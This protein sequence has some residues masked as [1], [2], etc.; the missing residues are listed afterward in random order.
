MLLMP[1]VM[2]CGR[3]D[4]TRSQQP[5]PEAPPVPA[6][7][8]PGAAAPGA[9]TPGSPASKQPPVE[10]RI[11]AIG[12]TSSLD[13]ALRRAFDP[14][15]FEPMG[16]PGPNDWLA[17]HPEKPQSYRDWLDQ[18]THVIAGPRR[19]IYL[20]PIGTFPADAPSLDTLITIM[21]AFF[22]IDVRTLPAVTVAAVGAKTRI[23]TGTRKQQLLP[24]MCCAG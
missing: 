15:D 12:D 1:L 23:N 13:P 9:A 8:A 21:R 4:K 3:D 6:A 10:A 20:L 5:R 2:A 16:E 24:A 19:V 18:D 7:T 17:E 22:A 14:R 11:A